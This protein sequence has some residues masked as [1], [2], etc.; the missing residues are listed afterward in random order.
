MHSLA[1]RPSAQYL[2]H[3]RPLCRL[4]A[5]LFIEKKTT[6]RITGTAAAVPTGRATREV[7][8]IST[9]LPAQTGPGCLMGGQRTA[10]VADTQG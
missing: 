8:H 2:H 6:H 9:Q 4:Q 3:E 7:H 5:A 10:S 1:S